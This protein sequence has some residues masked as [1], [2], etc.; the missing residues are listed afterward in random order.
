VGVVADGDGTAHAAFAGFPVAQ[1]PIAGK[2]G[3]AQV[4]GKQ[5]T[6]AFASFAP[7][8]N[9]TFVVDAFMEEAGY[10]A[11]AAAPVVRR[12]Y[13]GL[14]NLPVQPVNIPKSGVD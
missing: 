14:F 12:I 4:Q 8:D 7:A 1:H 2:T 10:G 5:P 13:D 9:P 11:D 3:T 6:S